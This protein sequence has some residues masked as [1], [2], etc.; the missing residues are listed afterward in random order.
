MVGII[1]PEKLKELQEWLNT[2]YDMTTVI[3]NDNGQHVSEFDYEKCH[4]IT[5]MTIGRIYS[6]L[7]NLM[8]QEKMHLAEMIAQQEINIKNAQ[9]K[10]K[11]E[12]K[13]T[14][15]NKT[16]RDNWINGDPEVNEQ[17][18]QIRQEEALIDYLKTCLEQAR[19]LPG[20]VKSLLEIRKQRKELY[21]Q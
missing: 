13:Y 17:A 16:E 6:N 15:E 4:R 8:F 10:S 3:N 20:N 11:V 5:H 2:A 9:H 19:F 21:G 12:P 18:K 1:T 14:L 7:N